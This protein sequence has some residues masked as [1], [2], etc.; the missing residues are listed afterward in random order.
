MH[1]EGGRQG[2]HLMN[3]LASLFR[4]DPSG[5][6]A[7]RSGT[8]CSRGPCHA[9]GG[10]SLRRGTARLVAPPGEAAP[11][12]PARGELPLRLG[13]QELPLALAISQRPLPGHLRHGPLLEP[14]ADGEA[15]VLV[16]QPAGA[17]EREQIGP[18]DLA[19]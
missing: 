15:P 19:L 4:L 2:V 14:R 16:A 9:A 12:A 1:E 17:I 8:R 13:G 11:R 3:I 6:P 5:W 7:P 18:Q 10:S